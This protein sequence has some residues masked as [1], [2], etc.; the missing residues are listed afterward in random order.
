MCVCVC[1]CAHA[2][3]CVS[4]FV[5]KCVW[6]LCVRMLNTWLLMFLE[7]DIHC[8]DEAEENG[9]E[10][11]RRNIETDL[12]ITCLLFVFIRAF[13]HLFPKLIVFTRSQPQ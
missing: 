5:R 2:C 13:V 11:K 6:V 9:K 10:E 3:V 1:V 8:N 12:L 4:V 7:I